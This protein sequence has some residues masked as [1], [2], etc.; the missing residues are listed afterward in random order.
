MVV[1]TPFP[2][3]PLWVKNF[4]TW[5]HVQQPRVAVFFLN[6]PLFSLPQLGF[7]LQKPEVL[8]LQCEGQAFVGVAQEVFKFVCLFVCLVG[9]HL[10]ERFRIRSWKGSSKVSIPQ[11]K[12]RFYE[13]LCLRCGL[14]RLDS[15]NPGCYLFFLIHWSTVLFFLKR[16][17]ETL[18][19]VQSRFAIC[20]DVLLLSKWIVTPV[21]VG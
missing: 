2:A 15:W 5:R 14:W 4:S 8:A 19:K 21:Q 6:L 7:I 13:I 12:W 1:E 17:Y 16:Y 10:V 11:E 18:P 3:G 20:W 9:P